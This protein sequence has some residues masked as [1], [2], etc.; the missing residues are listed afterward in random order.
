MPL[1][2]ICKSTRISLAESAAS[3]RWI[4]QILNGPGGQKR[5]PGILEGA[6]GAEGLWAVSARTQTTPAL[7]ADS[8]GASIRPH[9]KEA[10]Q[11]GKANG[12]KVDVTRGVFCAHPPCDEKGASFRPA[13]RQPHLPQVVMIPEPQTK[14]N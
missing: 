8:S 6:H 9:K 4:G 14:R 5:G 7:W 12:A 13:P 3:V 2:T 11:A 10:P 1:K